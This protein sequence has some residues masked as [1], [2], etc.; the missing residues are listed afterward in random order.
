MAADI[1][2]DLLVASTAPFQS[3]LDRHFNLK[4]CHACNA[5]QILYVSVLWLPGSLLFHPVCSHVPRLGLC[6]TRLSYDDIYWSFSG[7]FSSSIVIQPCHNIPQDCPILCQIQSCKSTPT[8]NLSVIHATAIMSVY[9]FKQY[10]VAD[11]HEMEP[12]PAFLPQFHTRLPLP[13]PPIPNPM[14]STYMSY[15]DTPSSISPNSASFPQRSSIYGSSKV[16]LLLMSS[17]LPRSL[18]HRK[19]S[20]QSSNN[21]SSLLDELYGTQAS[22]TLGERF[23][24]GRAVGS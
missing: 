5:R 8:A 1:A 7:F 3:F 21:H 23:V 2:S 15:T 9:P 16:R 17:V 11:H 24:K 6:P 19:G 13:P 18:I 12:G 10:E 20:F 14:S 4:F 22:S